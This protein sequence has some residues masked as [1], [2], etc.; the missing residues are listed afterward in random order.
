LRED[1]PLY[2]VV[3]VLHRTRRLPIIDDMKKPVTIAVTTSLCDALDQHAA[4]LE[5]S[6]SWAVE[7]AIKEMLAKITAEHGATAEGAPQR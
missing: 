7:R 3:I 2:H 5:R 6:R 4:R 1:S